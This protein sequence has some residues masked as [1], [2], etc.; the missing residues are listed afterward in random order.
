MKGA[1]RPLWPGHDFAP[2]YATLDRQ[3]VQPIDREIARHYPCAFIHLHSTSMFLL[4]AFLEIEE[5]RCFQINYE[6]HTGGPPMARMLPYFKMVQA[7][8]RS[9]L[10]RGSFTPDELRLL[11]DALAPRG[12]YVYAM[13]EQMTEVES[14]RAVLGM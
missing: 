11:L 4:D 12:L 2:L 8:E 5:L 3:F 7:A 13:V 14:L 9:L 1:A 10:V 6:V